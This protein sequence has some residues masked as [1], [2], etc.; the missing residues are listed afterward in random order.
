[1]KDLLNRYWP[2]ILT[3]LAGLA[4]FLE[5]SVRAYAGSH[6]NYSV[7]LLTV[8]TVICHNLQSPRQS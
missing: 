5:P 4:S 3:L 8:W 7:P 2:T 1:M 6:A